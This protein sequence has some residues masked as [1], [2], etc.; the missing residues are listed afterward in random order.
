[1]IIFK[2]DWLNNWIIGLLLKNITL[3]FRS[4]SPSYK[5]IYR[6]EW[7]RR[8]YRFQYSQI[9]KVSQTTNELDI[10]SRNQ[11]DI[12][13]IFSRLSSSSKSMQGIHRFK[14][15]LMWNA[16]NK[17]F[18]LD[19]KIS[20]QKEFTKQKKIQICHDS[21]TLNFVWRDFYLFL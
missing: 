19:S 7:R 16:C 3:I 9:E 13:R 17:N 20:Y 15:F 18:I 11:T 1:M 4:S 8:F 14:S 2:I 5:K 12:E 21:A 6:S 10:P